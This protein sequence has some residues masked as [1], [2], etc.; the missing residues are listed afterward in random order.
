MKI[1]I[2][3][4]RDGITSL[5]PGL[6]FGLWVQGCQRH[7]P[8]CMS[9]ESQPLDQGR[10][11][12][13]GDLAARII[14]SGRNEITISGGEP[15]LQAAAL[16]ELIRKV[17][18]KRD[19][20]VIL[21]TGFALEELLCCEKKEVH[22][23]LEQCDLL[24]DGEYVEALNDGK[25]LRGSSNQ[26]AIPLTGRYQDCMKTF[27]TKPAEVEFFFEEEKICMVG[28][29]SAEMLKRFKKTDF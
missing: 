3:D 10:L 9:P 29:P 19:M 1:R 20:G 2:Y 4:I 6:R 26:R 18:Q 24:V 15:F 11:M 17:R 13:M 5:G 16:S 21:Y 8:G 7:C 22:S 14:A 28:V 23:L 25:N 12:D 27:G